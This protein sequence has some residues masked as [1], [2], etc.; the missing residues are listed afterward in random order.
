MFRATIFL[1]VSIFLHVCLE[2]TQCSMDI[3][4]EERLLEEREDLIETVLLELELLELRQ[5]KV[6]PT[7]D[8]FKA[9]IYPYFAEEKQAIVDK[10]NE[11]RSIPEAGNMLFLVSSKNSLLLRATIICLRFIE[12]EF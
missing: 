4:E 11:K 6:K 7:T 1:A 5:G 9:G 2:E 12:F 10:H 8:K 3:I